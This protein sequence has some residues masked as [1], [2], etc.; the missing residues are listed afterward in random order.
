MR[1]RAPL[2]IVIASEA[3]QSIGQHAVLWIAS[4]QVLLAMTTVSNDGCEQYRT[5]RQKFTGG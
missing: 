1:T 3:K 2:S 5:Q 4:S